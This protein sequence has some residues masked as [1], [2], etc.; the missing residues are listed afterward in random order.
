MKGLYPFMP[1]KRL[2][3]VHKTKSPIYNNVKKSKKCSKKNVDILSGKNVCEIVLKHSRRPIIKALLNNKFKNEE[4]IKESTLYTLIQDIKL[5]NIPIEYYSTSSLSK[6]SNG[7]PN[8]G[9]CLETSRLGFLPFNKYVLDEI[10]LNLT[11]PNLHAVLLDDVYDPINVGAILRNCSFFGVSNVFVTKRC[12]PLSAT[13]C[14]ASSGASEM[15][16]IYSIQDTLRFV[17]DL[18]SRGWEIAGSDV[19]VINNKYKD[20]SKFKLKKPTILLLG[21]EGTGLS[22]DVKSE[23]STLLYVKGPTIS[24]KTKPSVSCLNVSS[25][26]A[27]LLQQLTENS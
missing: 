10:T 6:L 12:A 16:N 21:S 25:A 20:V 14:K 13:T 8:Q 19:N 11:E 26:S 2:F 5:R 4:A 9:I 24:N 1:W 22:D 7:K 15:T 18:K 27:I 23:C 17:Q 3:S